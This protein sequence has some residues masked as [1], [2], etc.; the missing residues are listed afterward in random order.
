MLF[1]DQMAYMTSTLNN[2]RK[3]L[4]SLWKQMGKVKQQRPTSYARKAQTFLGPI[5]F[6]QAG[7]VIGNSALL[8]QAIIWLQQGTQ[9]MSKLQQLHSNG[10][11]CSV[12]ASNL[13]SS[14]AWHG[15]RAYCEML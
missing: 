14:N 6:L 13:C 15:S 3:K 10:C 1:R 5:S 4:I 12:N 7:L 9:Q 2:V 8:P 11:L